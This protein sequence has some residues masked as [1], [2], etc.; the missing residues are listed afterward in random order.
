MENVLFLSHTE[1]NGQLSRHALETLTAASQIATGLGG[2]LIV[3]LYGGS[4]QNAVQQVTGK[5]LTV[6]GEAFAT[7]RY[8]TDAAAAEALCKTANAAIV[9]APG[10]SRTVRFLSGVAARLNGKVDAHIT[11]L[12][13]DD[14]LTLHRWY[15]RQRMRSEITRADRPWFIAIEPGVFDAFSGT[16]GTAETVSVDVDAKLTRTTVQGVKAPEVGEQTI[17]PDAEALLVA[18]AK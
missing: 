12:N 2:E 10:T 14:G 3:G 18:G 6:E 13:I 17:R 5:T 8:P 7:P 11:G 9:V 16:G 4:V 1:E 15:Y